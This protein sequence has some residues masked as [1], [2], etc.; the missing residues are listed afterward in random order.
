MFEPRY[1]TEEAVATIDAAIV[2]LDAIQAISIPAG[3]CI[4]NFPLQPQASPLDY[5]DIGL[6]CL[7]FPADHE[8]C[9]LEEPLESDEVAYN[10]AMAAAAGG[11]T[12]HQVALDIHDAADAIRYHLWGPEWVNSRCGPPA[13]SKPRPRLSLFAQPA[14]NAG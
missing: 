7:D 6:E 10:I 11:S 1:S 3:W 2:H 4:S 8:G 12:L 9:S 14:V 5:T 13:E